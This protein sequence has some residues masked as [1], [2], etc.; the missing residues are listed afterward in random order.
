MSTPLRAVDVPVMLVDRQTPSPPAQTPAKADIASL[1]GRSAHAQG[2]AY[3]LPRRRLKSI[4]MHKQLSPTRASAKQGAPGKKSRSRA[5]RNLFPLPGKG[6][7][8]TGRQEAHLHIEGGWAGVGITYYPYEAKTSRQEPAFGMCN[9]KWE[10]LGKTGEEQG[11]EGIAT[12]E[13]RSNPATAYPTCSGTHAL[14][15]HCDA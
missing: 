10:L 2:V 12:A 13:A 9:P 8:T 14:G 11:A 6:N 4:S 7:L 3:P 15:C 1:A 5:E